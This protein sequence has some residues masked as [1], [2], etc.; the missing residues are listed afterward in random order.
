MGGA[1]LTAEDLLKLGVVDDMIS[2][3]L[4]GAHRDFEA[5]A[6]NVRKALGQAL[7]ELKKIPR[8]DL[9]EKRYQKFRKMGK[10]LD[11]G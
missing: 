1:S 9:P 10:F 3:P 6:E 11:A 8:K 2:E 5:T 7:E 4:G